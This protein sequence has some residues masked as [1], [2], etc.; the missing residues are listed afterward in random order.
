VRDIEAESS[1]FELYQVHFEETTIGV[2][3]YG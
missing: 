1:I 3:V 2:R